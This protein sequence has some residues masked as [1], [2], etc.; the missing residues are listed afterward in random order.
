MIEDT[1]KVQIDKMDYEWNNKVL[2]HCEKLGRQFVF[3]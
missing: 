1:K 2:D 3:D